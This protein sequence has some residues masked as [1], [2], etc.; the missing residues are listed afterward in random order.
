MAVDII[1]L[2]LTRSYIKRIVLHGYTHMGL[3]QKM[4][5][6]TSMAFEMTT[7]YQIFAKQLNEKTNATENHTAPG[8]YQER[9]ILKNAISGALPLKSETSSNTLDISAQKK[10][11]ITP[12]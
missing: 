8:S 10:Q 9:D 2:R 5:L 4:K 1:K 6:I 3:F 7:E 12:I 11:H